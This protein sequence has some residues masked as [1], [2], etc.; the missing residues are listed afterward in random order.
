VSEITRT[1]IDEAERRCD[2][3]KARR[4]PFAPTGWY[5]PNT[6]PE[7]AN[8]SLD[9][10]DEEWIDVYSKV[11]ANRRGADA[12]EARQAVTKLRELLDTVPDANVRKA[13][14]SVSDPHH[15]ITPEM[16]DAMAALLRLAPSQRGRILCWFCPECG[17]EIPP[18]QA[19]CCERGP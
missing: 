19:P 5:P 12:D 9:R 1:I 17:H 6:H 3:V 18:G 8:P 14:V 15:D 13:P 16:Q 2:D 10:A 7:V 4:Q 11:L